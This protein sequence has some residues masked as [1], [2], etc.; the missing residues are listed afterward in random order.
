MQ[1]L[2]KEVLE[3]FEFDIPFYYRYV[4]DIV[5]AIPTSK[6]DSI[7]NKFNSIHPRLQFIIE[8]G[9]S[10]INFLDITIII[11]KKNFV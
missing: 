6:I 3:T 8:I 4:D 11:R 1:D 10:S 7:F 9:K 5:L 2:E